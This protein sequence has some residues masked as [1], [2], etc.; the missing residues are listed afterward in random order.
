MH[1][2]IGSIFRLELRTPDGEDMEL[3]F[4]RLRLLTEG[5]DSKPDFDMNVMCIERDGRVRILAGRERHLKVGLKDIIKNLLTH[6]S[7]YQLK[8]LSDI[9][10]PSRQVKF[11]DRCER[12]RKRGFIIKT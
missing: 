6:N 5:N 11:M 1:V 10:E 8:S 9:S 12:M 4:L 3:Q 7:C 2:H